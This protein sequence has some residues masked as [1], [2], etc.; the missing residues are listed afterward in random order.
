M[1]SITYPLLDPSWDQITRKPPEK[2]KSPWPEALIRQNPPRDEDVNAFR[3]Q[4]MGRFRTAEENDRL[5]AEQDDH[6]EYLRRARERND[7][8][9]RGR[10]F[11]HAY[12]AVFTTGTTNGAG[13]I[14]TNYFTT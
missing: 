4:L 14:G 10:R 9:N 11:D 5:Q 7:E 2:V 12:G 8:R 1:S 13:T 6:R 3:N